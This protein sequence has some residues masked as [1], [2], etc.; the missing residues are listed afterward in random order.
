MT[1]DLDI[2]VETLIEEAQAILRLNGA[3][4]TGRLF[5]S[6]RAQTVVD[7]EGA[8]ISITNTAPYAKYIDKGTYA[9]KNRAQERNPVIRKYDAIPG[10]S[11]AYPFNHKGIE[12]IYFMEAINSRLPQ[13]NDILASIYVNYYQMEILREFRQEL[14]NKK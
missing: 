1:P 6:F 11:R 14:E 10:R 7:A 12:P 4:K 8:S 2:V 13:L 9:W 5:N 3:Y